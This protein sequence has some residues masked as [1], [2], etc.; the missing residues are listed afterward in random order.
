MMWTLEQG[1]EV[2]RRI[3]PLVR[4]HGYYTALTGGVLFKGESDKDLDI[5]LL[6]MGA[7]LSWDMR[8][9]ID[10]I[11]QTLEPEL[12]L[13]AHGGALGEVGCETE[14]VVL[15][16]FAPGNKRVD[17]FLPGVSAS[18]PCVYGYR[19]AGDYGVTI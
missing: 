8:A 4:P 2:L 17:L 14:R 1:L 18:H 7:Q 5:V 10:A 12:A 11:N 3:N 6:P 16:F 9:A 15:V 19:K 13:L